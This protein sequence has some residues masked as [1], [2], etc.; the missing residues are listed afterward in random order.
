MYIYVYICIYMYIYVYIYIF[1]YIFIYIYIYL[2]HMIIP[3]LSWTFVAPSGKKSP[4]WPSGVVSGAWHARTDQG[5]I[6]LWPGGDAVHFFLV[7][8][9]L[10]M[11][12][13][14]NN[15]ISD[16]WWLEPW[17]FMTF[18]SIGN[19][20]PNWRTHI[21]QRGQVYHQ[22]VTHCIDS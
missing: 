11:V 15:N 9:W 16:W 5:R 14:W 12:N 13:N 10:I 1:I 8:L 19:Y 4:W 21:F 7:Y 3:F 18:H 2:Y 6:F 20:N 17:N 22:P